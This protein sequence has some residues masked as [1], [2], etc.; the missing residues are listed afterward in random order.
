MDAQYSG[1]AERTDRGMRDAASQ[2]RSGRWF[3]RKGGEPRGAAAGR[4]DAACMSS[5]PVSTRRVRSSPKP[6]APCRLAS[7]AALIEVDVF[8]DGRWIFAFDGR[9]FEIFGEFTVQGGGHTPYSVSDSR[10]IH[11]KQVRIDIT[12]P[13][14]NGRYPMKLSTPTKDGL[15]TFDLDEVAVSRIRPLVEAMIAAKAA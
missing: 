2:C 1:M 13:D 11:V 3:R 10:R 5:R 12:G 7:M 6:L 14:R 4:I 8:G 15:K 9:V